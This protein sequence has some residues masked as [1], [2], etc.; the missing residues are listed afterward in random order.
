MKDLVSRDRVEFKVSIDV[1]VQ[2]VLEFVQERV[3]ASKRIGVV[4]NL[5][6]MARLLW[7]HCPQEPVCSVVVE[8]PKSG[9]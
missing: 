4:E 5:P 2:A 1:D 9:P 7:G 6:Q 8:L 3:P